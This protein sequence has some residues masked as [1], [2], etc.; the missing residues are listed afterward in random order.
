MQYSGC[1]PQ[2]SIENLDF[3]CLNALI[4][5]P[6]WNPMKTVSPR[7]KLT[8]KPT[9]WPT[10]ATL[11]LLPIL[12][13]LGFWQWHRAEYKQQLL[14]HY[15]NQQGQPPLTLDQAVKD[16][17]GFRYFP[18][19]IHGHYIVDKQFLQDNQF[20]EHQVG[21]YVL[22]PFITDSKQILLVNRGWV[23]KQVPHTQLQLSTKPVTLGGRISAAPT[24]TFH[25]GDNFI[26]KTTWPKVMQVIKI[27]ELSNALGEPL[28]PII[29][30]LDPDQADGFVRDWQPQGLP[31]EKHRA[32]ALQWFAFA[33]LLMVIFLVLNINREGGKLQK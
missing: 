13:L 29:L 10:L 33:T 9:L 26:G 30:L 17:E 1:K 28:Q 8:F 4:A 11:I 19:S 14:D 31:P 15:T 6:V 20:H 2:I 27:D 12:I 5:S 18:L 16:P 24:R 23:S 22:T 25:L 3:E 32:Y 21:Y 7:Q